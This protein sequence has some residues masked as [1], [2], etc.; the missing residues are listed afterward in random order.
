MMD[1]CWNLYR[2]SRSRAAI[3]ALPL[4]FCFLLGNAATAEELTNACPVD[5][6]DVE[7]VEAKKSGSEIALTLKANI[8]PDM[9]KN[10]IH[11]WWGENYTIEQV[12]GNAETD[13]KVKQGEWHPTDDYPNY[14]TQS[15]A[16]T[17]VRGKATTLCVSVSDGNHNILDIKKFRCVDV[18]GQL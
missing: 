16:S 13:Y 10:H 18:S 14:V 8:K 2:F 9:S 11:V 5:G 1:R 17:T 15:G 4:A 3:G 6:C 7:I 12:T